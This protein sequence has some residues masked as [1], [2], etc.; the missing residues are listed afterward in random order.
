[1]PRPA[2]CV[3][4]LFMGISAFAG[5]LVSAILGSVLAKG[6]EAPAWLPYAL[7]AALLEAVLAM[8]FARRAGA[9]GH[10]HAALRK[11]ASGF[12]LAAL[13]VVTV[14]TLLRAG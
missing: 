12:A 6:G 4:A 10:P 7:G 14:A 9:V 2:F 8:E 13:L 11:V 1:M 5:A 3:I